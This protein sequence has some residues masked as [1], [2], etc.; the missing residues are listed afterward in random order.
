MAGTAIDPRESRGGVSNPGLRRTRAATRLPRVVTQAEAPRFSPSADHGSCKRVPGQADAWTERLV[1]GSTP[2][3]VSV[4]F[5]T[6][7]GVVR[8]WPTAATTTWR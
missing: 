4:R 7:P 1:F 2:S 5:E 3:G 8:Y 6:R